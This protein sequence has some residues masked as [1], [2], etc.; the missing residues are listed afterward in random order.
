LEVSVLAL[1]FESVPRTIVTAEPLMDMLDAVK[2]L[3]FPEFV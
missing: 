1:P 2:L 3:V